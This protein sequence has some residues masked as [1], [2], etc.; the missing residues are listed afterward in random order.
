MASA[1]RIDPERIG[2]AFQE[3]TKYSPRRP[4]RSKGYD[5]VEERKSYPD[6][7]RVALPPPPDD[8]GPGLWETVRSRRSRRDFTG[9]PMALE[10]LSRVLWAAQG[11]TASM[12]PHRFR[13]APSAGALYPC[14]TYVAVNRVEGLDA[15]VYHYE[16]YEHALARLRRGDVAEETAAAA[17]GQKM[18]AR[19][20]CNLVW[21]AVIPRSGA[22]Y[23]QRCFRY[24]YLDA[25]HI[26]QNAALAAVG[27]GLGSCQIAAFFDDMVNA[28]VGADGAMET[29]VYMTALG[30]C[31]GG[32]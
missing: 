18:C 23:R 28:L 8:P 26:A 14:E 24:I 4:V 19:A 21:T 15:G 29:A 1:D 7:A 2:E 30:A 16:V 32:R 20:A 22:K 3:A 10:A 25:G 6:A 31:R 9:E 27:I 5:P 13:A 17:A 12:G 11:V